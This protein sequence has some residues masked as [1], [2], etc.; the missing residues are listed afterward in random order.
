MLEKIKEKCS[1]N[2]ISVSK[3]EVD[4]K[5]SKGS[6]SKWE[7]SIPSVEKVE[8]VAD[9]FGVTVDELLNRNKCNI[10]GKMEKL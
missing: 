4:L 3:L 9:Y 1:E 10:K 5:F 7:K 2:G 6:I 8:K